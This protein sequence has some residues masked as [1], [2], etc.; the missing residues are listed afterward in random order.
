MDF[1]EKLASS[2]HLSSCLKTQIESVL[3]AKKRV[4]ELNTLRVLLLMH[5][6]A[7]TRAFKN[8]RRKFYKTNKN[9]TSVYGLS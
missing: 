7:F 9:Y 5:A 2:K 1:L 6:F 4:S 8:E 3:N